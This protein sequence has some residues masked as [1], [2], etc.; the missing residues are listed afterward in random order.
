MAYFGVRRLDA[1]FITAER[2]SEFSPVFQRR[3]NNIARYVRRVAT[4]ELSPQ[5]AFI[6]VNAI[7][8]QE[9]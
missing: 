8:L 7:R 9:L 1:A 6:V 4:T 2:F 3:D 5:I